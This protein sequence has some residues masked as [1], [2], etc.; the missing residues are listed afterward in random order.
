MTLQLGAE[1][2]EN[3]EFAASHRLRTGVQSPSAPPATTSY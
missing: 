2:A 1:E 3:G